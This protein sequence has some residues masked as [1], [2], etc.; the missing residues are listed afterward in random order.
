MP[1]TT[2]VRMCGRCKTRPRVDQA[3]R[4]GN[5]W[6]RPC[7]AEWTREDR[8]KKP[9]KYAR[10]NRASHLKARYGITEAQYAV[11]LAAQ[12]GV[13]KCC[14]SPPPAQKRLG[15]DHDHSCCPGRDSCGA[16]VRALLCD[17]CNLLVGRYELGHLDKVF[18]YLGVTA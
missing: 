6:C 12:G 17:D 7:R 14:G 15:V 10:H 3:G 5:V 9:E 13:C 8:K 4:S 1:N 2:E 18:A 16:C 11:M